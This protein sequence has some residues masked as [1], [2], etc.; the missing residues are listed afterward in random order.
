MAKNIKPKKEEF[1]TFRDVTGY[2]VSQLKQAEPSCINFLR[3]KKYKVTIEEIEEPK[4][5]YIERLN[6]MF[7]KASTYQTKESIKLE[8]KK[9]EKL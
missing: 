8:L 6:N 9:L 2:T 3:Y 5:V 4:E 1:E 7:D